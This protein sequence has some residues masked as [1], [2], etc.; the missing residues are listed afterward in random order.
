M[1]GPAENIATMHRAFAALNRRDIDACTQLMTPD[2]IINIA[3]M[4]HQKRGVPAWR[5][6]TEILFAAFP[7]VHVAVED[8]FA[9]DDRLAV[10]V[11][12]TG[13]H[14]GEF[15]GSKPTGKRIDYKSHEIYRFEDGKLAEEWICSDTMTLLTQIGA[16]SKGQL[17]SM[18][19]SGFRLWLGMA[20][21]ALAGALATASI[22]LL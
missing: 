2:F 8:I 20:V 9:V 3:E 7:D 15:M 12:I 14:R 4:P 5:K 18:W 17:I 16:L 13:T 6:H 11:R 10:R 22:F 1:T 21:G 19:L